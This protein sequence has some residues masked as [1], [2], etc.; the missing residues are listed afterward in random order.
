MFTWNTTNF[1]DVLPTSGFQSGDIK[2][3]QT[4]FNLLLWYGLFVKAFLLTF[5][6]FTN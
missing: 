2:H 1:D 5:L 6:Y 3:L 4:D